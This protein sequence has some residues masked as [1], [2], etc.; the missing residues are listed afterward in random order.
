MLLLRSEYFYIGG[1]RKI[2]DYRLFRKIWNPRQT[3]CVGYK[4][5]DGYSINIQTPNATSKFSK[6]RQV[7]IKVTSNTT[8]RETQ[9]DGMLSLDFQGTKELSPQQT[10]TWTVRFRM[11]TE[12]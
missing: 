5:A 12:S 8:V 2:I 3:L 4:K 7:H 9:M 11:V 1:L 6:R 10:A